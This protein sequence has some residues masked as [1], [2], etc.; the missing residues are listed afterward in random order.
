MLENKTSDLQAKK[1]GDK[2]IRG[3]LN[4]IGTKIEQQR[5]DFENKTRTLDT[6]ISDLAEQV[7]LLRNEKAEPKK[8]QEAPSKSI[9]GAA[10][11]RTS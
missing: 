9:G 6:S 11:L 2:D 4:D 8:T 7:K 10:S 3:K 1:E 5:R